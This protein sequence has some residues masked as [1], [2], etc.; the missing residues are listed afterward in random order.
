MPVT[1]YKDEQ[2]FEDI[3]LVLLHPNILCKSSTLNSSYNG[4]DVKYSKLKCP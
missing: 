2:D 3:V 4:I 1:C